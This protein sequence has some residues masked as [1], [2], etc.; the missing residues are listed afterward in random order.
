[1]FGEFFSR[2]QGTYA[3]LQE[4]TA[5]SGFAQDSQYNLFTEKYY[6]YNKSVQS[7]IPY[8]IISDTV[9]SY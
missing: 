5:V 9:V 4:Q 7:M 2:E 1:M 8:I 6:F 3:V